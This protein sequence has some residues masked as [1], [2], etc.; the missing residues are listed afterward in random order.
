MKVLIL[1]LFVTLAINAEQFQTKK[2]GVSG[3][4]KLIHVLHGKD[5]EFDPQ[6]GSTVGFNLKY[7][8]KSFNGLQGSIGF[9]CYN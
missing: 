9:H 4:I 6:T 3:G 8:T 1:L 7:R 2:D 5:N